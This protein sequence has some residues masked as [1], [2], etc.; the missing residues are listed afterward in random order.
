[1]RASIECLVYKSK[2]LKDYIEAY[3]KD[4][5]GVEA[6]IKKLEQWIGDYGEE[7]EDVEKAIKK[8]KGGEK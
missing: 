7:L 3:R 2:T 8:L 6:K 1:M 5:A 4:I